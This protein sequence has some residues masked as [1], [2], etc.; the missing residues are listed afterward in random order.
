MLCIKE[1]TIKEEEDFFSLAPLVH[2]LETVAHDPYCIGP[3]P[4]V[5]HPRSVSTLPL[6]PNA[7]SVAPITGNTCVTP[8]HH[9]DLP[10]EEQTTNEET[11]GNPCPT[12]EQAVQE[13]HKSTYKYK[14]TKISHNYSSETHTTSNQPS[15][16]MQGY[17]WNNCLKV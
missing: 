7:V 8:R 15:N 3:Q 12:V 1:L 14:I 9:V 13:R 16:Q 17:R 5:S 11:Y 6:A 10:P 2:T 4:W